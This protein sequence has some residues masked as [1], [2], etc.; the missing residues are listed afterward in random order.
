MLKERSCDKFFIFS[1]L[2]DDEEYLVN[3]EP[4]HFTNS[5]VGQYKQI[6]LENMEKYLVAEGAGW[7]YRK[8]ALSVPP[9]L[10]ILTVGNR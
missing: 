5:I 9:N 3:Y 1:E 8:M 4:D 10:E 2:T 7:M 6:R